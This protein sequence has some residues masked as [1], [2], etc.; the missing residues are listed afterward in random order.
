MIKRKNT[1]KLRHFIQLA[2]AVICNGYI[3]GFKNHQIF[4]GKTKAFCV[5][6]LNCYSCPGALGSCPIGSLQ[7]VLGDCNNQFSFYVLGLLMLFGILFGRLICG[8]LCPF[9]FIQEL[10]HKIPL[11]KI[12]VPKPIDNILRYLKY[13]ILIFFVILGPLLLTN[14]FGIGSP[15]FCKLICP[16]GTLEGGLPLI[17]TNPVLKNTIGNLFFWKLSIL[18]LLILASLFI[19][20]PFCKYICP[21][22]AIYAL[23]SR[24]S[25]YRLQIDQDKCTHCGACSHLCKMN[26]Q[27]QEQKNMSECILCGQ[28]KSAC[29]QDAIHIG[30]QCKKQKKDSNHK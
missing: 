2:S 25:F 21:L 3:V 18:I 6:V 29:P 24:F 20:R 27:P 16:A 7:A 14:R 19:Y 1:E 30:F 10:L 4:R 26:A 15:Y 9:G 5:P 17:F 11:P 28:C 13:L 12:Q 23:F 22:G 8:F